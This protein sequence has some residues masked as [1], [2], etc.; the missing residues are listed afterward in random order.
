MKIGVV[1]Q[2]LEIGTDPEVLRDYA[3]TAEGAGLDHIAIYDHVLGADTRT[4][5]DWRGPYTDQSLFHEPL[6]LYGFFA[7]LTRRIGFCTSII[8]APQRQTVLLAKQATEIDLLS[9]GRLRLGLGSGWNEVEY[10][11]LN[12]DFH[13]RG[14]KLDEQITLLRRLWTEPVVNFMGRFHTITAAGLNPLPVQRPIP[15]WLGGMAEPVLRRVASTADGWFPQFRANGR[16]ARETLDKVYEYAHAAG[17][18]PASIGI[19]GR[20]S[21]SD[22]GPDDWAAQVAAWR[23]LGATHVSFNTMGANLPDPRAHIDAVRRFAAIA[24]AV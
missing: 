20:F 9:G 13:T 16:S 10:E 8:I 18:D 4:R 19:E 17:R 21:Y 24:Q 14:R 15:I 23:D 2:Q 11:G 7:G 12:E 1:L 3:Q 5:P 22:G 6:V